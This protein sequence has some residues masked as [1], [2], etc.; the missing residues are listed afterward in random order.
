MRSRAWLRWNA[1]VWMRLVAA[2]VATTLLV[3]SGAGR[4]FAQDPEPTADVA[5]PSPTPSPSA[6]PVPTETAPSP[7][8]EAASPAP[9]TPAPAATTEAPPEAAS[10]TN[11]AAC[12]DFKTKAEAQAFYESE[13]GPAKDPH[14]LDPD[15]DGVACEDIQDRVESADANHEVPTEEPQ[16][17]PEP[18]MVPEIPRTKPRNTVKLVQQLECDLALA[19]G[20]ILGMGRFPVAGRAYYSD[21]WLR[22]RYTPTLH[23]HKGLDIFAAFGTPIRSPVTGV[24]SRLS[25]NPRAGGIGVSVQDADG[26]WYYFGHLRERAPGLQLGQS[27]EVGTILGYVGDTGNAR[28]G[29]PH[30]HFEIHENGVPVPP[31]PIV[32]GW[33][34]EAIGLTPKCVVSGA[35]ATPSPLPPPP[36]PPAAPVHSL[37]SSTNTQ[38]LTAA[39]PTPAAASSRTSSRAGIV[40]VVIVASLVGVTLVR[41]KRR[42]DEYSLISW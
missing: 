31:K 41:R 12:M 24:V 36:P 15:M 42:P 19:D 13:G 16:G 38:P 7:S 22:P 28:G 11:P 18:V 2:L 25:D 4:V 27:V 40:L 5:S 1:S 37:P 34:D 8:P 21:D 9:A 35:N 17:S 14:G 29:L 6:S 32:D 10:P 26:R 33:L 23:L 20:R 3:F 39:A 30:L